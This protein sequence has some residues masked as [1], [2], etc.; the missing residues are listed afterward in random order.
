MM[1]EDQV[2]TLAFQR[3]I[4]EVVEP[5]MKV[6][7]FGCGT[8]ILSFFAERA[9]AERVYAVDRSMMLHAAEGIARRNG[10]SRITFVRT[11]GGK[12]E[13]PEKIDVIIS[14]WLGLFVFRE[15]ML[16][17]LLRARDAHLA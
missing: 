13:L 11:D 12:F 9:G 10:F 14:E 15:G 16:T 8:G 7:D 5:G 6:L 17:D 3:A 2:R 4:N 1:L